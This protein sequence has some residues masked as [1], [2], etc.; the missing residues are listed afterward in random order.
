MSQG[1]EFSCVVLFTPSLKS[2]PGIACFP[3]TSALEG[4]GHGGKCLLWTNQTA[5]FSVGVHLSLMTILY[6]P[7]KGRPIFPPKPAQHLAHS[8]KGEKSPARAAKVRPRSLLG[9]LHQGYWFQLTESC[10]FSEKHLYCLRKEAS[11]LEERTRKS[12]TTPHL[13]PGPDLP[14]AAGHLAIPFF[15]KERPHHQK[16]GD[17]P[18]GPPPPGSSLP[19][20]A[21]QPRSPTTPP[22]GV[23]G[24]RPLPP[25]L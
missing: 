22:G 14:S 19:S 2:T 11:S 18:Q 12:A 5:K 7:C 20:P 24:R 23:R 17:C 10:R 8:P 9:S 4:G 15:R 3:G 6:F 13:F 1:N 25:P 16:G 21:L